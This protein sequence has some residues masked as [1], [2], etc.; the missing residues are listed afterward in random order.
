ML[1]NKKIIALCMAR[2]QDDASNEYITALNRVVTPAGYSIFVYNTCSTV[3]VVS[4]EGSTQT[5]IYDYMDFDII[6]VVIVYEEVLR[7][8]AV[9]DAL[10]A[11]AQKHQV[12]VL[13][14]GEPSR[15]LY[16]Y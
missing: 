3:S 11:K 15:R 12:P 1:Y 4:Y 6:D 14:I 13:V 10:I 7:N 9:T 5:A 16:Q 2:I 8:Q